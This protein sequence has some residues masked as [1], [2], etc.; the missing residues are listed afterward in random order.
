MKLCVC[1]E[2][3]QDFWNIYIFTLTAIYIYTHIYIRSLLAVKEDFFMS[4][5]ICF[6]AACVQY[7]CIILVT[8]LLVYNIFK[9]WTRPRTHIFS[10][11]SAANMNPLKIE[12][13]KIT[14]RKDTKSK[15]PKNHCFD[16]P[17]INM[18]SFSSGPELSFSPVLDLIHVL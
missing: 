15:M 7:K 10:Q 2:Y 6:Q 11:T 8:L 5:N 12:L 1:N 18:R 17:H 3:G 13:E 14:I 16:F 4:S 9:M